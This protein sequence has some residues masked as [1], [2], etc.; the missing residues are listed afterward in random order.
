MGVQGYESK[1]L[2]VTATEC[3]T[4]LSQSANGEEIGLF[5]MKMLLSNGDF[6]ERKR[7]GN[8]ECSQKT[9]DSPV[10]TGVIH[11]E[12]GDLNPGPSDLQILT[13]VET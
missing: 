11:H 12:T 4:R 13:A 9:C 8:M 10:G 6:V 3:F 2:S 1:I 7:R 5:D